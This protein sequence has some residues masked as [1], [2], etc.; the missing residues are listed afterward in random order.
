M[1][2]HRLALLLTL[3]T[4]I[5]ARV[6]AEVDLD[7]R[8]D[9]PSR[10][11]LANQYLGDTPLLLRNLKPGNHQI[12]IEDLS[13]RE[14][15]TYLIPS[16]EEVLVE[17]VLDVRWSVAGGLPQPRPVALAPVPVPVPAPVVVQPPAPSPVPVPQERAE[18]LGKTRTRNVLLGATVMTQILTGNKR[19]RQHQRNVGLGAIGLNE[20]LRR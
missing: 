9:R 16:P 13:T 4:L 19:D 12:L 10:V 20:I 14:T 6:G 2:A 8:S 18:S 3:T 7:I 1:S 11:Y 5:P 17:R 15:R